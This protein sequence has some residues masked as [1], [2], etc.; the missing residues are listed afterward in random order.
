MAILR[1][2]AVSRR[3]GECRSCHR[4]ITWAVLVDSGKS[5]P[6]DGEVRPTATIVVEDDRAVDI[7]NADLYPVHFSTCPHAASWRRK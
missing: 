5:I 3:P 1:V 4:P 6:F 2:W 7:I